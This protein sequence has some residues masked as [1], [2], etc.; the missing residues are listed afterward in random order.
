MLITVKMMPRGHFGYA[1]KCWPC[2]YTNS[3]LQA[4]PTFYS[5][6][7]PPLPLVLLSYCNHLRTEIYYVL[8]ISFLPSPA[9]C[10]SL[11]LNH[12]F[13]FFY[14]FHQSTPFCAFSYFL[15]SFAIHHLK[16][17]SYLLSHL[18]HCGQPH[19]SLHLPPHCSY[20]L[21]IL[22]TLCS[23][24]LSLY[25]CFPSTVLLLILLFITH[26]M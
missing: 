9:P 4:F 17:L 18:P 22:T 6:N 2:S 5:S 26:Y 19:V 8:Y 25:C 1:C 14:Y 11:I 7:I 23:L 24:T 10:L 13:F 20:S 21:D 12:P 16:N 3:F 15:L